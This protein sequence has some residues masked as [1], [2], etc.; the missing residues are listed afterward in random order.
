MVFK[1]D[2]NR[3][4]FKEK[5]P[6]NTGCVSILTCPNQIKITKTFLKLNTQL[7]AFKKNFE[8]CDMDKDFMKYD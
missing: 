6:E 2:S 4:S 7:N 1:D 8:N 5:K 3:K